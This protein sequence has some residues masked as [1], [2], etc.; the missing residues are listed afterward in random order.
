MEDFGRG[1]KAMNAADR[2]R[3]LL[4]LPHGPEFRFLDRV[5][6]LVPG[7]NGVGIYRVPAG[8]EFIRGHFPGEP[9]MPGV[10]LVEAVAQLGGVVAQSDPAIP[11]LRSLKLTG[12]RSAKILGTARPGQEITVGVEVMGRLGGLVQVRGVVT[13]DAVTVLQ[14]E[15]TLSGEVAGG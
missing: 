15:V 7:R 2:D 8:A 12:I 10:L 6:D 14:C 11:P 4:A 3:A 9:M 1:G 5:T 13:L